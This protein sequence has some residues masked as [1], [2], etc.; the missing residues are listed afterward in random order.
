MIMQKWMWMALEYTN[1]NESI[2]TMHGC[3]GMMNGWEVTSVR[4][5]PRVRRGEDTGFYYL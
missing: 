4:V 3:N 2:I 5:V 1:H